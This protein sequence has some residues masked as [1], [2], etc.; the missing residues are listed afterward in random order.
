M[1]P[2]ISFA[3]ALDAYLVILY[4]LPI[5]IQLFIVTSL[6]FFIGFGIIRFLLGL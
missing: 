4:Y 3:G 2:I 6:C 5:S 1:N